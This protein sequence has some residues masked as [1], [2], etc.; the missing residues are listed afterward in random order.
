[1]EL[2]DDIREGYLKS[3]EMLE[4]LG[5]TLKEVEIPSLDYTVPAYYTIAMAEA[6]AN[7][8]RFNGI[9][10]GLR[11]EN[12]ES[13]EDLIRQA[14]TQGFGE[15]VKLRI[16]MGTYVLRSGFQDQYYIKAQKIRTMIKNG[17]DS[18]FESVDCVLMPV[19]PCASFPHGEAGLTPFQ[20][21]LA[22]NY[23]SSAN[24]AGI[25]ALSFPV[26]V[27]HGLPVGMQL[28]APHFGEKRL[29]G[30]ARKWHEAFPPEL[31][32]GFSQEWA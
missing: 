16:L 11:P 30:V 25:P 13:Y 12:P 21:K 19:F 29:F 10:Y 17:F 28:A 26:T 1:M 15:E 5:Y 24:L 9:R 22:D 20:Q 3:G 27:S 8:A 7:L 4:N 23:T 18:V 6:S 32:P 31:C 14:R 2:N